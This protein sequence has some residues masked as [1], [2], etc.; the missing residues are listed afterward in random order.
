M[1][2]ITILKIAS[3]IVLIIA[4]IALVLFTDETNKNTSQRKMN[5]D[6]QV[7]SWLIE[8]IIVSGRFIGFIVVLHLILNWGIDDRLSFEI[9]YIYMYIIMGFAC[10][11]NSLQML[12][13]KN[14]INPSAIASYIIS[15]LVTMIFFQEDR[16]LF[17][18][19][20]SCVYLIFITN[21]ITWLAIRYLNTEIRNNK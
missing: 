4:M 9:G 1:N 13:A 5:F 10:Y 11:F 6:K 19:N 15:T 17:T 3:Y 12:N 18:I 2:I 16:T 14:E 8:G 20:K 7:E 21:A